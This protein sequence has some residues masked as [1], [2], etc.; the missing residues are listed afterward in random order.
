MQLMVSVCVPLATLVPSVT[1]HAPLAYMVRTANTIANVII[2][3]AIVIMS[4]ESVGVYQGLQGHSANSVSA[5][6]NWILLL[7]TFLLL[8]FCLNIYVSMK[9]S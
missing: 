3:M 5:S 7:F 2:T 1:S 4:L 6:V 8:S 9:T